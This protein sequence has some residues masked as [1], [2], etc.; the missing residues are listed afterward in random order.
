M[1]P[2]YFLLIAALIVIS[3]NDENIETTHIRINHYKQAAVGMSP[4]LVLLVQEGDMIGTND[5]QYHSSGISG[6]DYEWGYI[7][8]HFENIY[9][10]KMIKTELS[11]D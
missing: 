9:Y 11:I 1:R 8:A 4:I 5:W 6:F 7:Y 10:Q 3:C 2:I